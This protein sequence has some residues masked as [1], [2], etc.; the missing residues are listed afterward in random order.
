[1]KKLVLIFVG[2]LFCGA[3]NALTHKTDDWKFNLSGYGTGMGISSNEKSQI[4]GD[5]QL[6]GSATYSINN[7]WRVGATLGHSAWNVLRHN[8]VKDGFVFMENPWGRAEVGITSSIASKLALGLP[9]VGGL[10]FN[11]NFWVL[12]NVDAENILWKNSVYDGSGEYRINLASRP[13]DIQY[14]LS[15]V[16][17]GRSFNTSVDAGLKY[18][19]GD[20]KTKYALSF[21][22][23]FMDSPDGFNG[24]DYAPKVFSDWRAGVSLGLNIQYNS[25]LWGLTATANYDQN[26]RG[27]LSDGIGIGSGI[28][29]DL[30]SWSAS[31][32]YKFSQI[33]LFHS[34]ENNCFAHTGV[35]SIRYKINQFWTVWV[36]GG[37]TRMQ[38]THPF[39]AGG[40][41]LK[42]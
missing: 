21:G 41:T 2:V 17:R 33:G 38:K 18:K 32:S 5:W 19:I 22:A 20:G 40:I 13:G 10:Q 7:D 15:V 37:A 12:R 9:D 31:L 14:G 23:M 16:P 8:I 3:A 1:M 35:A 28:S 34:G 24:N 30:L 6:V 42:F 36:S 29:Y 25:F 39:I 27:E 11:R 26:P 4:R